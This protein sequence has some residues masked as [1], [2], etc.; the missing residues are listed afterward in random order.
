MPSRS[1]HYIA[2]V[3]ALAVATPAAA[4]NRLE[5]GVDAGAMFGLG[6]Q[7]SVNINLP[8]SRFRV[9][10]FRPGSQISIE[11]AAG[12]GYNKVEGQDG[13][14]TY[15]LQ[16]GALYHFSPIVVAS[17]GPESMETRVLPPYVRPFIGLNGFSG[18]E[19]DDTEF[20]VGAG[21]GTNIPWRRDI[22][23]RLEGNVGYGFDN[24]AARIGILA[25]LSFFPR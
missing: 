24:K 11:P 7:S 2:L 25:G 23:I 22:A 4:Q 1:K 15:D 5:L 18:G 19:S 9:G 16:L 10:F 20:S 6:D 8:G 12:F 21:L 14:F 13:I 17:T 3:L